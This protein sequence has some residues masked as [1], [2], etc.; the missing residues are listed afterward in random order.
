MTNKPVLVD[1]ATAFD[2]ARNA[3]G[4][5][6]GPIGV[7][8]ERAQGYRY[9]TSPQLVQIRREAGPTFLFDLQVFPNLNDLQDALRDTWILH[10]ADQDLYHLNRAG[11]AAG[12]VFDTEIAGKLL[13]FTRFSLAAITSDVLGIEL[14]KGHQNEDWSLR[15]LPKDWLRYAAADVRHLGALQ[16]ALRS[17]LE[18]AGRLE[19]AEQEF[20][21]LLDHPLVPREASWTHLKGLNK[22]R[23]PEQLALAK[24]LWEAREALGAQL[25]IA[26][27]RLLAN[28]GVINA[29]QALPDSKRALMQ[30]PE[31]RRPQARKHKEQWWGAVMKAKG[32][33][34]SER[35][36]RPRNRYGP[37]NPPPA[38]MLKRMDPD[39]WERLAS[40]RKLA[41]KAAEM[42]DLD[43]A[44]VLEPKIQRS[45]AWDPKDAPLSQQLEDAGA[46]PWQRELIA[47]AGTRPT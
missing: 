20:Q 28:Q 31:L 16:G 32:L 35:P 18:Q 8:T 14:E 2:A 9:G 37:D 22:L 47:A 10:A 40:L 34:P 43:P 38:A 21:H 11:L 36:E 6:T 27:G 30:V 44:V 13:G 15:P 42:F 5:Q 19:W 29:A 4:E 46:R 3:L 39:A 33:R 24:E 26:P 12:S 45:L 1:H 23:S 41:A 7:D 17:A 25:D